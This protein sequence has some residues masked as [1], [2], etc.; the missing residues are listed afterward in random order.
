MDFCQLKV[1]FT[2]PKSEVQKVV[3]QLQH[4]YETQSFGKEL[5][6][7]ITC[8]NVNAGASP[9]SFSMVV[10]ELRRHQAETVTEAPALLQRDRAGSAGCF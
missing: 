4:S 8:V 3:L 9:P 6:M 10:E 5:L 1:D 7:S 2:S